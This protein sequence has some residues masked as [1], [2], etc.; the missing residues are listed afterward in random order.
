MKIVDS[1]LRARYYRAV[2]ERDE[3]YIGLFFFAV[4]TTGIFCIPGCRAKT[5]REENVEYFSAAGDAQDAGYRPCKLCCPTEHAHAMPDDVRRAVEMIQ[6]RPWERL[7]DRRLLELGIRPERLR[8]WFRSHYG[9]T[10]QSYQRMYRIHEAR[11]GIRD[12]ES[13]TEAAFEAGY[14]SLSGFGAGFKTL[15]GS[16]P[17]R[18]SERKVF[19]LQ[20]MTTPLGPLFIG[21]GETGLRTIS[22]ADHRRAE[23]LL[24]PM[25]EPLL[26]VDNPLI[27]QARR[28]IQD[29]FEG[30]CRSF[31]TPLDPVGTVLQ[32]DLWRRLGELPWGRTL[33]LEA[34]AREMAL[35]RSVLQSELNHNPLELMVPSHR[36][37]DRDFNSGEGERQ[38]WLLRHEKAQSQL[39]S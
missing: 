26:Y 14:E 8:R 21:A 16:A 28:E 1:S 27:T 5:P 20:R 39:I 15:T 17:V 2:E 3:S 38:R 32:L 30:K 25:G 10:F 29:Y 36:I 7:S 22:F 37:T 31:S 35:D 6:A 24:A 4:K 33:S 13:V 9:I 34:L 12:G 18:A 11:E 23:S 19:Y